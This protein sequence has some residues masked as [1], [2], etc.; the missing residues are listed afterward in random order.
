MT[1]ESYF[2]SSLSQSADF[3]RRMRLLVSESVSEREKKYIA[4]AEKAM[5]GGEITKDDIYDIE[6]GTGIYQLYMYDLGLATGRVYSLV[7]AAAMLEVEPQLADQDA[8]LVEE[9]RKD[10]SFRHR[11]AVDK[12]G[13]AAPSDAG[14]FALI[15]RHARQQ[16]ENTDASAFTRRLISDYEAYLIQAKAFRDR[17]KGAAGENAPEASPDASEFVQI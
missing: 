16:A 6:Y 14:L 7:H 5:K 10:G 8:A 9:I 17:Q 12:S 2:S 15:A 4:L 13:R 11:F 3:I 1:P